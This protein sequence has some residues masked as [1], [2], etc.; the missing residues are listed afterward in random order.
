MLPIIIPAREESELWDQKN[1]TF[2]YIPPVKEQKLILEHSLLSISKWEEKWHKAFLGKREKT[3]EE[4]LDYIRCMTL[5]QNVDPS[6]Y[7]YIPNDVIE[8]I[9]EYIND[10][11]T[12]IVFNNFDTVDNQGPKD[13][14]TS[15]V[16]Y[17][18][19]IQLNIPFS[20]CEKWHLNK[21]LALIRVCNMKQNN[22][23]KKMSRAEL[24][25]RNAQINAI[26]R[27]KL[28]TKG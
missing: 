17:Y 14:L 20:P 16:I 26:Q 21:L 11:H 23:S 7:K 15:E 22:S 13:T 24:A 25:Q 5:T 1:E 12:S 10:P 28:N 2:I 18:Y 19:M 27:R 9:Q 8:K 6:V 3:K 4:E